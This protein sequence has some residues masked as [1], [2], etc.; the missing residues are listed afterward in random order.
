MKN[1]VKTTVPAHGYCASSCPIVLAGGTTPKAG[2]PAW[3]GVHQIFAV[4]D[5]ASSLADGMAHAQRSSARVV[6]HLTEMGIDP[7]AWV[8][9][10]KTPTNQ[11]YLFTRK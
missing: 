10:M 2:K 5:S 7:R 9:A 1:D 4:G 11:L 8:Q 3:V 6:E